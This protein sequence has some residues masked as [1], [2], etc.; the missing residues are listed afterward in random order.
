MHYCNR[1]VHNQNCLRLV[2]YQ[3]RSPYSVLQWYLFSFLI[4]ILFVSRYLCPDDSCHCRFSNS[5]RVYSCT[6]RAFGCVGFSVR[7]VSLVFAAIRLRLTAI[8]LNRNSNT[9]WVYLISS[10]NSCWRILPKYRI[11]RFFSAATIVIIIFYI[12]LL[13]AIKQFFDIIF[14]DRGRTVSILVSWCLIVR[15]INRVQVGVSI[16]FICC[17]FYLYLLTTQYSCFVVLL[18]HLLSKCLLVN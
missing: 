1:Y 10:D 3:K 9:S 8:A 15:L 5:K 6:S 12:I 17:N 13:V 16:T 18:F 14:V 2:C 11:S 4:T 7:F